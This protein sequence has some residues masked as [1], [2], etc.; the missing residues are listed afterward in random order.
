M[1]ELVTPLRRAHQGRA[2]PIL[3]K[4]EHEEPA[5]ERRFVRE[6]RDEQECGTTGAGRRVWTELCEFSRRKWEAADGC[7]G[8][9]ERQEGEEGVEFVENGL[10]FPGFSTAA[11][12]R[13]TGCRLTDAR[14]RATTSTTPF[15]H[16]SGST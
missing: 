3:E 14:I 1:S 10:R 12:N 9:R 11:E 7:G 13:V 4:L 16:P 6:E 15:I 8:E 5:R 2:D